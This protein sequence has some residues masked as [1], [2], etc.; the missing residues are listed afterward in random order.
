MRY[1]PVFTGNVYPKL[2]FTTKENLTPCSKL[3]DTQSEYIE[4]IKCTA[5]SDLEVHKRLLLGGLDKLIEMPE[6]NIINV[7]SLDV[8]SGKRFNYITFGYFSGHVLGFYTLRTRKVFMVKQR[9]EDLK[10]TWRHEV[11]HHVLNVLGIKDKGHSHVV[12][13][14]CEKRYH[15]PSPES[16]KYGNPDEKAFELLIVKRFERMLNNLVGKHDRH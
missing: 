14:K 10:T 1:V 13:S 11:Q 3:F 16:Y 9:L 4:S 6:C 15:T 7:D 12:W 5:S 2:R 8:Y